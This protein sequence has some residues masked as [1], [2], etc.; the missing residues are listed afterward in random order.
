METHENLSVPFDQL[1]EL[2]DNLF[3]ILWVGIV[4]CNLFVEP[5]F[6]NS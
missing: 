2:F 3:P 1:L 5:I 4:L 6:G